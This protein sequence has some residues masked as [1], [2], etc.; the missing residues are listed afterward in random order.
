MRAHIRIVTL[1]LFISPAVV[2]GLTAATANAEVITVCW[3]GSGDYLT[4]QEGIDAAVDGD[5][6]VVC[7]GVYTGA[8]NKNLDFH[9]KAI[10][11][12]SANGPENCIIDCENDGRG[13]YFHS[14]ETV[15]SLVDGFT[16]R[17]GRPGWGSPGY[18]DGGGVYCDR[19]SNPTI[20][21]CT[22]IW[23]TGYRHGG[24]VY[25]YYSSPIIANC[26]IST[27]TA[28]QGG[29]ISCWDASPT[30][31]DC[32]ISRNLAYCGGGGILCGDAT[33]VARCTIIGNSAP[34]GAG[35]WGSGSAMIIDCTISGNAATGWRAWGGGVQ[36]TGGGPTIT[37][38]TIS[39]NTAAGDDETRGAGV[40]CDARTALI[41]DCTITE[42]TAAGDD[43][44]GGGLYCEVGPAQ[45]TNCT[46]AA[47]TAEAGAGIYFGSSSGMVSNCVIAENTATN[48]GGGVYCYGTP[49]TITNCTVAGNTATVLGGGICCQNSRPAI[50]N[51]ILWG[52][53]AAQGPE[54]ALIDQARLSVSY[55]DVEGGPDAAYVDEGCTLN[56]GDG[57]LDADPMLAFVPDAHLMPASP[58][59]DTATN[60]PPG[61]L[62]PEDPDGNPRPLDGDGDSVAIADMGAY[63]FNPAAPSIACSPIIFELSAYKDDPTPDDQTLSIR[64]CGP[65]ALNWK[66]LEECSWLD[67]FPPSGQS[68]GEIDEVILSLDVSELPHGT[69][70][71]TLELV[72]PQAV[73]S[74]RRLRVML[75][76]WSGYP[77]IQSLIDA[78][79]EDEV[80]LVADGLYTGPGN[81]NLDFHGKAITLRSENGPENCIIDCQRN[82][83]GFY[84]HRG[85]TTE[86]TIDGFTIRNAYAYQP[87]SGAILC[88]DSSP[89][90]TNCVISENMLGGVSCANSSA[91]ISNCIV[92]GNRVPRNWGGGGIACWGVGSPTISYCTIVG[93]AAGFAGGGILFADSTATIRNCTIMG[94][95]VSDGGAG[96][97]GVSCYRADTTITDCTITGN[98]AESIGGHGG[99]IDCW[100]G[101]A[102]ITNCTIR[103]NAAYDHGGGISWS[104]STL[105][106]DNCLVSDN[107]AGEYGG[108]LCLAGDGST[109]SNCVITGNTAGYYGGG[110]SCRYGD[111][112]LTN[113]TIAGNSADDGGG[114]HSTASAPT[115]SNCAIAANTANDDG[116]AIYCW[117]DNS[118]RIV[119]C[120]IAANFA[121]A[122]RALACDSSPY[123]EA[124]NAVE[125][126]NCVLWDGDGIRN[127]DE[128]T[129]TVT[130]S[131]V[132]G[133]WPGAGN[134]DADPL[135]VDPDGPDDDPNTW[136]D[137]DF[138]LSGGSPCIDAGCNWAVPPD[139]ADLDDD[140]D[141][142]EI[143]P[144][145]LDG[146]GRFF[147]DPDTADTGCTCPP[148]V[149]MGAYEYGGTGPQPCPG[150]LDCD[151]DVDES[152]L[153]IL[154]AAWH[155][156]A[157]GDLNCDG[158]TD[159]A[160]LGT[161]L[162]NWGNVCP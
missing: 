15:A 114:V 3:D 89:T 70:T 130:Y 49:P 1:V 159:H 53:S 91:M 13:F 136:E 77:T 47:N 60:D 150:D 109:V 86:S 143:T 118:A 69:Y 8:G 126:V 115:I 133:G 139:I 26:T 106:I 4:I 110:L 157:D 44:R 32:T 63:E 90:I 10:T 30:V 93:N 67:V 104:G 144:L 40:Y 113:C 51:C 76:L 138:H 64:N 75:H 125:I 161:L 97:A 87:E 55:S 119:N 120:T 92:T 82:G 5:E 39:G 65:G 7:D 135:F 17:N 59:I 131:D 132:F 22:I 71:C 111:L 116:G 2:P 46:V 156:S 9:G 41:T 155:V 107:T 66:V 117:D 99:G 28:E 20:A 14:D 19:D 146:E 33:T 85:E 80:V 102:T 103:A 129:I 148:I 23:N 141:T 94:N 58:C 154:L 88:V 79:E 128:S 12:R 84:F 72:D 16:M 61:G 152:D 98:T 73:N 21:N 83:R 142:S 45:L 18:G 62:P 121:S 134:I 24:G 31:T 147:D 122:G 48:S 108:G 127:Y 27:N 68:T 74:P 137:N 35:V 37:R 140:G 158:V 25:C 42:N 38:C 6:V 34:S 162:G 57:N 36:C 78:A 96:G 54:I 145:D 151:R 153:G 101:S 105:V 123:H 112:M 160:D 100:Q 81:K 43:T 50:T 124:P 149:D 95:T 29:G 11:V 52:D 56:W